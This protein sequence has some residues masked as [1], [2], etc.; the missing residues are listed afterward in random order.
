MQKA[1]F[2][3][4]FDC[5]AKWGMADNID[6]KLNNVLINSELIKVYLNIIEMLREFK[7][8]ATFAFVA[9]L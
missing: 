4:S 3:I 1:I 5:E 6:Q 9:A 7:V 2:I 8:K